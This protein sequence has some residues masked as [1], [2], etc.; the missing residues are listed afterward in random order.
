MHCHK[1]PVLAPERPVLAPTP[2]PPRRY[3][4]SASMFISR[5]KEL[6]PHL[7]VVPYQFEAYE[8]KSEQAC[9]A[10]AARG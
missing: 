2:L 6:C 5:A 9:G 4:V 3:G 10:V 1:R 7:L 8:E